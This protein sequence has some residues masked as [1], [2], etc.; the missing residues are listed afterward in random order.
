MAGPTNFYT[1]YQKRHDGYAYERDEEHHTARYVVIEA[2]SAEEANRRA[3]KTGM[4]RDS[5]WPK[6]GEAMS[7]SVPSVFSEPVSEME[8]APDSFDIGSELD[9]PLVT[10]HYVDGR[11]VA[12]T[13]RVRLVRTEVQG[14]D[15]HTL[16]AVGPTEAWRPRVRCVVCKG[17][18]TVPRGTHLEPLVITGCR[19]VHGGHPSN[20]ECE[21][22]ESD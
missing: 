3:R 18:F 7:D 14:P 5:R 13:P 12:F 20:C 10:V 1:F 4:A 15:P 9:H 21:E 8:T 19:G 2:V 17:E 11:V 22:C 16:Q 6:V